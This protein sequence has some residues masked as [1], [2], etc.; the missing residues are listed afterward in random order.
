MKPIQVKLTHI[1]AE[2]ELMKAIESNGEYTIPLDT[3]KANNIAFLHARGGLFNR[4]GRESEEAMKIR[5]L[6]KCFTA[7][8]FLEDFR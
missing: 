4:F 8:A 6:L 5:R 7:T 2:Q 3:L 1:Q